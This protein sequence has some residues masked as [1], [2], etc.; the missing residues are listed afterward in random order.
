[1]SRRSKDPSY[2]R[3]PGEKSALTIASALVALL[4]IAVFLVVKGLAR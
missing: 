4:T 3:L 2:D 1:M